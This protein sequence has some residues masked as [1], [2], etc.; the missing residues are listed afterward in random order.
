MSQI[1]NKKPKAGI[2][3]PPGSLNCPGCE[4]IVRSMIGKDAIHSA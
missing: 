4:G 2:A 3:S 1:V